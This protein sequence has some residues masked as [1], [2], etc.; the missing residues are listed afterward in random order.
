MF[1]RIINIIK[2]YPVRSLLVVVTI[3]FIIYLISDPSIISSF[4]Q[5]FSD[6]SSEK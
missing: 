3:G 5:G 6:G 4:H 2:K 1:S